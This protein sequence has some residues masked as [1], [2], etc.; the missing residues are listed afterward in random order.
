LGSWE[1]ITGKMFS[2][3]VPNF[4]CHHYLVWKM[5]ACLIAPRS[6][7]FKVVMWVSLNSWGENHWKNLFGVLSRSRLPHNVNVT[8]TFDF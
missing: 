6:R 1:K 7:N 3:S 5:V 2:S 4:A 8:S